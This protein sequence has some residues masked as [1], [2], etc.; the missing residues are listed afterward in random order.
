MKR[1]LLLTVTVLAF[2]TGFNARQLFGANG[3]LT[4][5]SWSVYFS[6]RGG[7]TEAVVRE[8]DHAKFTVLVQAYS[9]TFPRGLHND[10]S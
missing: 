3:P 2:Y 8:L 9:F 1:L 4:N 10:G 7:C 6:P 5:N